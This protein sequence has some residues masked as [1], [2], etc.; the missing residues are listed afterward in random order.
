VS[1]LEAVRKNWKLGASDK[2]IKDVTRCLM[3]RPLVP[4][5][6]EHVK[7]PRERT[8]LI[9]YQVQTIRSGSANLWAIYVVVLVDTSKRRTF[10][11]STFHVGKSTW[12]T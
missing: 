6:Q 12:R 9:T 7:W 11:G 10:P 5:R 2:Q 1:V 4:Q 3:K 8:L